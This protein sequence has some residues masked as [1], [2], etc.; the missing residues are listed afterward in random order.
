MQTISFQGVA[1]QPTFGATPTT[2]PGRLQQSQAVKTAKAA[3]SV[4]FGKDSETSETKKTSETDSKSERSFWQKTK[5]GLKTGGKAIFR[6]RKG[7]LLQDFGI[8]TALAIATVIIPPHVHA[9]S[10]YPLAF[11]FG[12]LFRFAFG[13]GKGFKGETER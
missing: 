2:A 3:D 7:G 12:G 4:R 1:P 6:F 13:A 9:L 10:A 11:L 8:G 5:D